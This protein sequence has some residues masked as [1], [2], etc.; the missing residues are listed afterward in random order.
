MNLHRSS[1]VEIHSITF[2][3]YLA[4][5]TELLFAIPV[6]KARKNDNQTSY[7][8]LSEEQFEGV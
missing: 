3:K 7:F 4:N 8:I 2:H 1:F 6:R 5:G